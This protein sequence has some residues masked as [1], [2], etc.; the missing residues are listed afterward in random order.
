MEIE[1]VSTQT[2]MASACLCVLCGLPAAGKSTLARRILSTAAQHGWRAT[3]VPYDD[4]I[5]EQAFRTKVVEDGHTEWKSHRQ[6][7]LY[8]I[9][10]F[11]QK[12]EILP[13]A[14]SSSGISVAAWEQCTQGLMGPKGLKPPLVFLLDDNFYYPSMRYEVCQ[15]ARKYSLGFCQVYLQCDLESCISR[16]Q[17]RSQP[18]PTEVILEMVKRLESPNPQKFSWE[19]NSI[20]LNSTGTVQRVMEL[21]SSALNNPLSLGEDN[22]EQKYLWDV[23][24]RVM[25]CGA[26]SGCA[27]VCLVSATH[28][29]T[30]KSFPSEHWQMNWYLYSCKTSFTQSHTHI[31]TALCNILTYT[32]IN[33]LGAV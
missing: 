33:T 3:V 26:C 32:P 10:Q 25:H 5:P 1:A 16:N 11:L 7:V 18:V 27:N 17:S 6:A 13:E 23:G 29:A 19:V 4:L 2:N 20:T 31:H 24:S 14:P 28:C 21:I 22:K 15:L 12:S 9:E 30:R 8:C